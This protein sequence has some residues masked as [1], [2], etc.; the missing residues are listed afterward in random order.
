MTGDVLSIRYATALIELAAEEKAREEVGREL[1]RFS[2]I[3]EGSDLEKVL[4]DPSCDLDT[5]LAIVDDVAGKLKV[6]GTLKNFVRLLVDKKRISLLKSINESY[7]LLCD[8]AAGRVKTEVTIPFKPAGSDEEEIRK[9][10]EKA[11]G[12]KV[13]MDISVDPE[14]IGGVVARVGSVIYD[15][16]IRTQLNNIKNN[17]MKG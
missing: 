5:K 2:D 16:S 8:E 7:Q 1:A 13:I 11:T 6:K 12:K 14:L 15:G 17:M 10:L 3:C 4:L 9:G